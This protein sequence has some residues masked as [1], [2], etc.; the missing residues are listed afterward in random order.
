MSNE[1]SP[2][3]PSTPALPRRLFDTFFDPGKMVE[4]MAR[5]PKWLGAIL[6]SMALVAISTALLPAELM[7]EVQRRAALAR[8]VTPPPMTPRTLQLIRWFSIG[9][10]ALSIA[11]IGALISGIYTLIFAFILGDEG[12]YRQ[13]F[14]I[15][16]HAMFI[17][18]LFSIALVPLRIQTG[19]PQFTLS[20]ASFLFF[21]EP[22]Y[23]LNVFRFMDLTQLWSTAVIALGAHT[24]DRRRGFG[25]ALTIMLVVTLAFALV[26]A[27]FLPT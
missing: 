18:A 17:P 5:D 16:A 1:A 25:S 12:R 9:G 7:V 22:G 3:I 15:F 11:I 13:Y 10:G 2:E 4:A 6:V 24:I 20:L 19:D 14:A 21:M 23:V 26:F 8:G 27:N